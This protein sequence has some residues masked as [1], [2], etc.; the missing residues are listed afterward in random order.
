MQNITLIRLLLVPS[1]VTY[2]QN[3]E[4]RLITY[5]QTA[6][7]AS[8]GFNFYV[9]KAFVYNELSSSI[10]TLLCFITVSFLIFTFCFL[11]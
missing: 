2:L 1:M 3:N 7:T 4:K 9:I 10:Y 6:E 11:S 5:L 8:T